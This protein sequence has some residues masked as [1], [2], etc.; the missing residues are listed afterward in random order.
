M[1]LF[2]Q[3]ETTARVEG[4]DTVDGTIYRIVTQST[5]DFTSVGS[6][7]NNP[8][9]VFIAD[10]VDTLGAGDALAEITSPNRGIP[11]KDPWPALAGVLEDSGNPTDNTFYRIMAQSIV[12]FTTIGAPDNNVGTYFYSTGVGVALS[13]VDSL[14]AVLV[15]WG[16]YQ[17]NSIAIDETE[18]AI[19]VIRD[20]DSR[21]AFLQMRDAN[22]LTTDL[23]V[24]QEYTLSIDAKVPPGGTV[25]HRLYD[26]VDDVIYRLIKETWSTFTLTFICGS[27]QNCNSLFGNLGVGESV[28]FRRISISTSGK[29]GAFG[30][31][32][33]MSMTLR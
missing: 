11:V 10:A 17:N 15:S 9:T 18:D 21:G 19:K 26:G 29:K 27:E 12:N 31:G 16:P 30:M 22:D 23:T 20:N 28:L 13:G 32:A 6:P 4:A 1:N 25:N 24:G 5:L 33:G 14:R 7:D 2:D 3:E 8:E